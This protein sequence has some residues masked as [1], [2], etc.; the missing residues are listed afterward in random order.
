MLAQY[1]SDTIYK[2]NN[3]KLNIFINPI[4]S[5]KISIKYQKIKKLAISDKLKINFL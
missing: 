1:I 4:K 3:K 5:I 2:K